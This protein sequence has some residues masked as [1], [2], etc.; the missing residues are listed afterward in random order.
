MRMRLRAHEVRVMRDVS[1]DGRTLLSSSINRT[2]RL[3]DPGSGTPIGEPLLVHDN[4]ECY[5][6]IREIE[7]TVTSGPVHSTKR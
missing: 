4:T 1:A 3:Q 5:V 7:D 2:V 6:T